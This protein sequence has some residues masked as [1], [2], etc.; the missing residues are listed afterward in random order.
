MRS[1][2]P[3]IQITDGRLRYS[4]W[5][6]HREVEGPVREVPPSAALAY[7]RRYRHRMRYAQA[8]AQ[9][10]PIGSGVA[11]AACKMLANPQLTASRVTLSTHATS[12]A[13][14]AERGR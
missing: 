5:G 7:F 4:V 14:E 6:E 11:E 8:Q 1:S 9:N 2:A 12:S 13:L 10:L 3:G